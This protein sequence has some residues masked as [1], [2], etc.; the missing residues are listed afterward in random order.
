MAY[1]RF[2][3]LGIMPKCKV[4]R[5]AVEEGD[6]GGGVEGR[7]N[8]AAAGVGGE[9]AGAGAGAGAGG[10]GAV[11]EGE[12]EMFDHDEFD[13]QDRDQ[14]LEEERGDG[15]VVRVHVTSPQYGFV[16]RRSVAR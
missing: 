15:V 10:M 14:A 11:E 1:S 12:D 5:G 4:C 16:R 6:F 9:G 13:D 8:V 3:E 7:G 2:E